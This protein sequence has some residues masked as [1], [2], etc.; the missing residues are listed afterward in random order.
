MNGWRDEP[1]IV[2]FLT[3]TSTGPEF[4]GHAT[5]HGQSAPPAQGGHGTTG[6]KVMSDL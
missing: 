3:K 4:I 6:H 1:C 5:V 2:E